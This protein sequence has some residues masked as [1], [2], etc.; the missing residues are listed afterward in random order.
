MTNDFEK[1]SE[2]RRYQSRQAN[3]QNHGLDFPYAVGREIR[4]EKYNGAHCLVK[5]QRES[6]LVQQVSAHGPSRHE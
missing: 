4:R 6:P 1:D 2:Y 5:C 3:G